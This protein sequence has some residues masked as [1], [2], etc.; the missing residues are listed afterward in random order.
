MEKIFG[1]TVISEFDDQ[2]IIKNAE[3]EKYEIN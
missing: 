2:S 1:E 3:Y